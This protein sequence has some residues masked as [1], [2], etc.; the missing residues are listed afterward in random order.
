[1]K[2]TEYLLFAAV[3]IPTLLLIVAAVVSLANSDPAPQPRAQAATISS[4]GLYPADAADE[5]DS[6]R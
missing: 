3:M 1:M 4:A 6:R 2:I 5:P